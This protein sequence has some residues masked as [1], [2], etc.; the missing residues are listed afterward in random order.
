ILNQGEKGRTLVANF[1]DVNASTAEA[2]DVRS[3]TPQAKRPIL[4]LVVAGL[5]A[6]ALATGGV[7]LAVG[8]HQVPESCSV[9][10]KEC[11]A[12]PGDHSF[13]EANRGVGTANLGLGIGLGG[14]A[15]LA[16]GVIWYFLQP[17]AP[18][19]QS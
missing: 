12:P 6:A 5:G 14:A 16:G 7:L 9:S 18:P 1:P 19:V 17:A 11:A 8:L 13:D 2:A 10:T 3:S 4:P 15:M